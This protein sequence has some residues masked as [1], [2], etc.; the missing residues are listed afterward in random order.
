[1]ITIWTTA[2][3]AESAPKNARLKLLKWYYNYKVQSYK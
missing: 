1:M 2:K 3:D